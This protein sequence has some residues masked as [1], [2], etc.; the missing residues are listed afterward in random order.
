MAKLDLLPAAYGVDL[1]APVLLELQ[2]RGV[3]VDRQPEESDEEHDRRLETSLMALFRDLRMDAAYEALYLR[4]RRMLLAWIVHLCGARGQGSDPVE[5]LQDTYVNVYRYAGGF[6]DVGTNSFR[7]WART[8]AANV[9]RRAR[10][11]LGLS[12]EAM[13]EGG[14]EVAD[15]RRNPQQ[16]AVDREQ[17]DDL[18]RAWLLV[19]LHYAQAFE[20]LSPRDKQALHMVEVEGLTYAEAG[21]R[22][23]VGRSN[24]KMIMFRSRKRIR[25]HILQAMACGEVQPRLRAVS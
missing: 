9:V 1:P 15:Q 24:M 23:Q 10:M 22:L 11:R 20:Q 19:L 2:R 5:L 14:Q 21:E 8:I 6:K 16:S 7:G 4:T 3:P 18:R 17:H 25:A 13:P 12:L